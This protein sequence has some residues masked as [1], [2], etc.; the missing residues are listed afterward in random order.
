MAGTKWLDD[1]RTAGDASDDER[2]EGLDGGRARRSPTDTGPFDGG[3]GPDAKD[4]P[5]H[6]DAAE[7]RDDAEPS[8]PPTKPPADTGP[9]PD[10]PADGAGPVRRD[11]GRHPD[12]QPGDARSIDAAKEWPDRGTTP[13]STCPTDAGPG[14]DHSRTAGLPDAGWNPPAHRDGSTVLDSAGLARGDSGR[15]PSD[16]ALRSDTGW[17]GSDIGSGGAP[18]DFG[19]TPTDAGPHLDGGERPDIAGG[20]GADFGPRRTDR[21]GYPGGG[22]LEDA[23]GG[24]GDFGPRR[25]DAR[26]VRDAEG[27]L[28]DSGFGQSDYGPRGDQG[29]EGSGDSGRRHTDGSRRDR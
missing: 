26:P 7:H 2:H 6:A 28:G 1:P 11:R 22:S 18:A 21:G 24:P 12:A 15:T 14:T 20:A 3:P 27:Y 8:T 10:A 9:G 23:G 13:P 29:N 5:G 17:P 4:D 19:P 16:A 25:V